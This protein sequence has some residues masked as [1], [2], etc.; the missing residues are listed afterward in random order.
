M[1]DLVIAFID[2]HLFSWNIWSASCNRADIFVHHRWAPRETPWGTKKNSPSFGFGVGQRFK[3]PMSALSGWSRVLS[4]GANLCMFSAL[5]HLYQVARM[6]EVDLS[7]LLRLS[8]A[9]I[10]RLLSWLLVYSRYKHKS[11]SAS[12]RSKPSAT[13]R[14]E[15]AGHK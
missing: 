13:T 11:R 4:F 12:R 14:Y 8:S 7:S 10:I 9:A 6:Q 15:G 1:P 3:G 2:L 5:I